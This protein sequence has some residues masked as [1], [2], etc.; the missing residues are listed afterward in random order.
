MF[1]I[2]GR[3]IEL[4]D[5]ILAFRLILGL[6]I[7]RCK[8]DMKGSFFFFLKKKKKKKTILLGIFF[9]LLCFL[10]KYCYYFLKRNKLIVFVSSVRPFELFW[11]IIMWLLY[12]I[13][14]LGCGSRHF[15]LKEKKKLCNV[16]VILYYMFLNGLGSLKFE[17]SF[18]WNYFFVL[19]FFLA[20]ELLYCIFLR[21]GIIFIYW[22][23]WIF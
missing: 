2:I 1:L 10:W 6:Y 3:K 17:S 22:I 4:F 8:I 13:P 15:V 11:A 20:S 5:G 19:L 16:Y 12:D 7:W 14:I 21:K 9:F 18:R 23:F